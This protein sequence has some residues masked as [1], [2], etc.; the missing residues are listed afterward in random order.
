MHAFQVIESGGPAAL[1]RIPCPEP[2]QGEIL[3]RIEACGLNFADLLMV[4]GEYQVKPP[5]PFSP[6]LEVA[7]EVTQT[8]LGVV[9]VDPGDRVLALVSYGG[10]AEDVIAPAT[11][12]LTIPQDMS[13]ETAAAF[14][15][16]YGTAHMA[17]DYRARLDQGETALILGAAGGVGLTAVE[18]AKRMGATVIAAASTPEKLA[19][20]EHY[21][22]DYTINYSEE[23]LKDKVREYTAGKGA[24][25]IFDPV[26][27]DIPQ[28]PANLPLVKNCSVVGLYWGGYGEHNPRVMIESLANLL[29]WFA[30]GVL[31][32]HVSSIY[33]LE[34]AGDALAALLERRS[35]GKL[36]L[37]MNQ[38]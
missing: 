25:V 31:K 26:G 2:G 23:N 35:R 9:H 8:G 20:T 37:T 30:K 32:P 22:A 21:G 16:A 4:R 27:G 18:I 10:F 15:I 6:G 14:P 24:D 34:K 17:L 36:V 3:L 38:T 5:L 7:G 28:I 1:S 19:L 11:M 33:P 29:Q 13:Y 12:V